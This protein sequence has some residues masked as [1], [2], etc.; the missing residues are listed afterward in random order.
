MMVGSS[1]GRRIWFD[2]GGGRRASSKWSLRCP[3][4]RGRSRR[5]IFRYHDRSPAVSRRSDPFMC[6]KTC[7][8]GHA[9][10]AHVGG[11][12]SA[13]IMGVL[14]IGNQSGNDGGAWGQEPTILASIGCYIV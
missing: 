8:A 13:T 6:L 5:N 11:T 1:I 3:G 4:A 9:S 7:G 12:D 14:H 10:I 2:V